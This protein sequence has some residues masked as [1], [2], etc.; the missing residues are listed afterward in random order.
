MWHISGQKCEYVHGYPEPY[1]D[2]RYA[3]S[4]DGI[5]WTSTGDVCIAFDDFL[6]A[7][8]RPIVFKEDNIYKMIYSYRHSVDYRTNRDQSYRIGYAESRDG[9][10]WDR[11]D[12]LAG[13]AKSE[14]PDSFDY[15]MI[16]YCHRYEHNGKKYLLHNGNGFGTSGFAY[17]VWED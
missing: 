16:N 12:D 5:H 9:I 6:H 2:C 13:I 14:D 4:K 11:K 7:V 1:Y 8:G 15:H 10:K 17:A 3:E